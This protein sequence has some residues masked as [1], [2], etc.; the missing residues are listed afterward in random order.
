[1]RA[2]WFLA[3]AMLMSCGKKEPTPV[4]VAPPPPPPE[5][6]A[7]AKDVLAAMDPKADACQDFYQY[8]CGGWLAT[9]EIPADR[10]G[11]SRSF[12]TIDDRNKAMVVEALKAAAA[13]AG[14]DADKARVG[15]F[16][17]SCMDEAGVDA[18]GAAPI[19]PLLARVA[20][21]KDTKTFARVLGEM[22]LYASPMFGLDADADFK[23]PKTVIL[24]VYQGGLGLPDRDY[25]LKEGADAQALRDAYV[26]HMADQ[27]KR[28]GI[29]DAEALAK[30]VFAFELA[31]AKTHKPP[32]EL[33][34][35]EKTYHRLERAGLQKLTPHLPWGEVFAGAGFP[36]LT[37]INVT[38]PDQV[39]AADKLLAATKADVLRGYLQWTIVRTAAPQLDKSFAQASFDF[40]GARLV[41]QKAMKTRERRCVEW[42]NG[43]YREIVGKLYVEKAFPG[44]SKDVAVKMITD[45]ETSFEANLAGLD[46]MDADTRAKAAEK[47]KKVKN[48]IGYPDKWRDY[49]AL[50]PKPD[51]FFDNWLAATTFEAK[52][53]LGQVGGPIDPIEWYMSAADVNAY[54]NPLGNEMAFPAGILQK[55][56]FDAAFPTEMNYGAI[57]MVM[58]HELTHGFDD[59][60]AKF[61]GDGRMVQWWGDGA[62]KAFEQRTQCVVD[63][64]DKYVLRDDLHVNGELTQ[65]EN[66]ADVGGLKQAYAAFQRREADAKGPSTVPGLSHEQLFFVAFAQGWCAKLT[67]QMEQLRIT[68]DPHSPSKFRVNGP[69]S[70][71]PEFARV[72]GCQAGA[73]MAPADRCTVW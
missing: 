49:S 36:D 54:Y 72:F 12:S 60:G 51:T 59:G 62:V 3:A 37:A 43:S 11:W 16:F 46:W 57:G 32:E 14:G 47:M 23:D 35:P 8:A 9:T 55:P 13:D 41:G 4:V 26:A 44:E 66:I 6:P 50:A 52:R 68:T 2:G 21:V 19:A 40:F 56:F 22:Q 15:A 64:Y 67:P 28:A 53:K 31:L 69:V 71:F 25:Y 65:G 45:I 48:K 42:T 18:K 29:A 24:H 30:K 61:D 27:L 70:Q 58:G 20:T 63:Q 17:T 38:D 7:Y 73:P 1:M 39:A 33:R 34:D 10:T 5:P